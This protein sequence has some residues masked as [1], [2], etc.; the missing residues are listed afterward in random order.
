MSELTPEEK[1]DL[2]KEGI[3]EWLDEVFATFGKWALTS[4]F[5]AAFAG[6][7][8]LAVIGLGIHK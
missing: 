3:K 5:A 8:Y 2:I 4:L 1:K 6:L 7:A